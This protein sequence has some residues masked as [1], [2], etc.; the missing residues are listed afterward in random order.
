MLV[1]AP[2]W[3]AGWY[4]RWRCLRSETP[5]EVTTDDCAA[6]PRWEALAAPQGPG[7]VTVTTAP[8][9]EGDATSI[10]P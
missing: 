6:C 9:S 7:N 10:A 2:L 5:R 3:L 1:A 4:L 8:P